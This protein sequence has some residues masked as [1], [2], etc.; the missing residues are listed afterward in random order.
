VLGCVTVSVAVPIWMV[1]VRVLP[2]VFAVTL[3]VAQ[4]DPVSS[5]FVVIQDAV[6]V[7]AHEQEEVVV[8][9]VLLAL[10]VTGIVR[11][12]GFSVKVQVVPNW[13]MVNV[14]PAIVSVPV[15]SDDV[16][17]GSTA[18]LTEPLPVSLDPD[19]ILAHDTL[20]VAVQLQV[21]VVVTTVDPVP[22]LRPTAKL[23]GEIENVQLAAA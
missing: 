14:L 1:P 12:V 8:T 9:N 10:A 20:L 4:P 7:V 3:K 21:S 15:R 19:V 17:V 18:N 23:V 13:V 6:V 22:P 5:V 2:V 16:L 11:A